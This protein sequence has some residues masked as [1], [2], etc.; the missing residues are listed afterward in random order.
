MDTH[1]ILWKR[2]M[3]LQEDKG[4]TSIHLFSTLI[5]IIKKYSKI[6]WP[7]CTFL[8]VISIWL[9]VKRKRLGIILIFYFV[10]FWDLS[11]LVLNMMRKLWTKKYC[12]RRFNILNNQYLIK[13]SA[14]FRVNHSKI[15]IRIMFNNNSSNKKIMIII[16]RRIKSKRMILKKIRMMISLYYLFYIL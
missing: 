3:N 9:K 11:I 1:L 10:R 13:V 6:H 12:F 16:N 8:L 15:I 14:F 5:S 7:F 2:L 4:E